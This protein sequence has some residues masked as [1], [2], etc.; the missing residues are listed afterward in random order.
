MMRLIQFLASNQSTPPVVSIFLSAIAIM[1]FL[2]TTI[3]Q[4]FSDFRQDLIT[5]ARQPVY[6]MLEYG[7]VK[8]HDKMKDDI[9]MLDLKT[10]DVIMY[11]LQCDGDFGKHYIP[12]LPSYRQANVE[13]A[14]DEITGVYR[15]QSGF[16]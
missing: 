3:T 8:Q 4:Q 15:K 7:L 14:C 1:V 13:E 11:T 10:S 16:Y 6:T 5:E 9:S 2:N 12:T